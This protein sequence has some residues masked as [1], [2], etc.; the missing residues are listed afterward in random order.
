MRDSGIPLKSRTDYT[1]ARA[2]TDSPIAAGRMRGAE[3]NEMMSD[4]GTTAD[5]EERMP[6]RRDLPQAIMARGLNKAITAAT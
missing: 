5:V 2:R 6:N 4:Y 3:G 1:G